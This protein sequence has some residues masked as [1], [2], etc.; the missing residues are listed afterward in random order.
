MRSM[1]FGAFACLIVFSAAI[2]SRIKAQ[3]KDKIPT[4]EWRRKLIE[5]CTTPDRPKPPVEREMQAGAF[6]GKAIS[7]PK[8]SYPAEAHAKGI[9]GTVRISVVTDENGDVIWAKAMEGD[10]LL[11]DASI[12]AACQSRYSPEKISGRPI[13]VN[14]IITYN[15]VISN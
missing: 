15:F 5:E 3:G 10:P 6:C 13:K 11:L 12:N 7:L 2:E 4:P 8:P 14:R 1:I 9:S